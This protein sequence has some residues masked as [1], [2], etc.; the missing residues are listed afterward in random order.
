[1]KRGKGRRKGEEGR[2]AETRKRVSRQK[3]L[4][5]R[6][7]RLD[8]RI[9]SPP[10][11]PSRLS[12]HRCRNEERGFRLYDRCSLSLVPIDP[13]ICSDKANFYTRLPLFSRVKRKK[14]KKRKSLGPRAVRNISRRVALLPLL[15]RI[16]AMINEPVCKTGMK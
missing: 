1:M 16:R 3:R 2:G 9:T 13:R 14:A 12:Q 8:G 10:L 15:I 4:R 6:I 11:L 7:P 5:Y